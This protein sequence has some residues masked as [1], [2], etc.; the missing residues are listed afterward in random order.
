MSTKDPSI[1]KVGSDTI[2]YAILATADDGEKWIS[3]QPS[4]S[5]A[6]REAR[7]IMDNLSGVK[8]ELLRRRVVRSD[9]T[10]V[11]DGA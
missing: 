8:C 10:F 6:A 7:D 5:T 2:E 4:L 3:E 9:W 11:K 1:L